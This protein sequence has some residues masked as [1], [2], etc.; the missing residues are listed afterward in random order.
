MSNDW[1]ELTDYLVKLKT[2]TLKGYMDADVSKKIVE[3]LL[4]E[5]LEV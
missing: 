3:T 1:Y 5:Y 2:L 4:K